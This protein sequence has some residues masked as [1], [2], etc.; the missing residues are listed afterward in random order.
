MN[1]NL[2]HASCERFA[3]HNTCNAIEAKLLEFGGAIFAFWW[4]F[5]H[6]NLV[7]NDFDWLLAFDNAAGVKFENHLN[8]LFGIFVETHSGNSPS[9]R[10]IYSFCTCLFLIWCS[11]WRAFLGLRPKSSKPDVSRSNRWMVRKFFKLY[12]LAK[13]KT[14]VL[15]L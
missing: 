13:I 8:E 7:R 14:T 2:M 15:C 11:I 6:T 12:S 10:Q 4:H 5:A 1:A 3:E 9:T